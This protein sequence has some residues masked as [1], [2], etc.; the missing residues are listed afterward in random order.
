M[1][2]L[3]A[4]VSTMLGLVVGEIGDNSW[5]NLRRYD[6][7]RGDGAHDQLWHGLARGQPY[8]NPIATNTD[9]IPYEVFDQRKSAKALMRH[10]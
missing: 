6:H 7:I 8:S 5:N 2:M 4:V 10:Y 1:A 9:G 3:W